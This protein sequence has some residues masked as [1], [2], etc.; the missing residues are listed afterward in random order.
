MENCEQPCSE[1]HET[2]LQ[3]CLRPAPTLPK[4]QPA[5]QVGLKIAPS[6]FKNTTFIVFFPVRTSPENQSF[7]LAVFFVG[8]GRFRFPLSSAES[9]C[10]GPSCNGRSVSS[11]V[12]TP[13]RLDSRTCVRHASKLSRQAASPVLSLAHTGRLHL[14]RLPPCQETRRAPE[15]HG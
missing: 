6:A 12:Q 15:I 14:L 4:T 13:S 10:S 9:W 1:V 3:T 5:K 7:L 11:R 2:H 8:S